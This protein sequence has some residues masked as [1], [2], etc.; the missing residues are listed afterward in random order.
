M[1]ARPEDRATAVRF[2]VVD[3]GCQSEEKSG[4]SPLA[5]ITVDVSALWQAPFAFGFGQEEAQVA[6]FTA[7]LPATHV[8]DYGFDSGLV[9]ELCFFWRKAK[10]S[11]Y[12]DVFAVLLGRSCGVFVGRGQRDRQILREFARA[13]CPASMDRLDWVRGH[14]PML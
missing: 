14:I 6:V 1:A 2:H 4:S 11:Q 7:K 10:T 8:I 5:E 13:N 3:I 12:G 9:D